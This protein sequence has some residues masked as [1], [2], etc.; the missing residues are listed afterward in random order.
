[1]ADAPILGVGDDVE[2]RVAYTE[3]W[4]A[5][6]QIASVVVGGYQIRRRSDSALLPA[7]TGPDDVRRR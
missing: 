5:G 3:S 1:M 6:F 4:S 7:P 2:V